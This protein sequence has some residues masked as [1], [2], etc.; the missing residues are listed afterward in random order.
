M[1]IEFPYEKESKSNSTY[2]IFGYLVGDIL[3][4]ITKSND[5]PII[6][7]PVANKNEKGLP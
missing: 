4:K 1:R 7:D 2:K 5:D 6:I 3:K